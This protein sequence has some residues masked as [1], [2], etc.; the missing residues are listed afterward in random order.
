[1]WEEPLL[2]TVKARGG[3]C[4]VGNLAS[5]EQLQQQG[6]APDGEVVIGIGSI[7][8]VD[9][10]NDDAIIV[11]RPNGQVGWLYRHEVSEV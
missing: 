1:M 11:I 2:M 8:Q 9:S 7:K 4:V 5:G 10:V 3:E 6:S